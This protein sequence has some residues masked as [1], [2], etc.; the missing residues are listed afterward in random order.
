MTFSVPRICSLPAAVA[1][2]TQGSGAMAKS[3]KRGNSTQA[4]LFRML[5]GYSAA[6]YIVIV[7]Q[8][9]Y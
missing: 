3:K 6:L 8:M 9:T 5:A 4:E 2:L 1:L 7:L